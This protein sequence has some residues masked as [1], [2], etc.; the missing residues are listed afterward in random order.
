LNGLSNP[1]VKVGLSGNKKSS[2][3]SFRSKATRSTY[4]V[5]KTLSPQWFD[6]SFVFDV[7]SKASSDP[8]ETRRFSLQCV[9]K[10][11]E[12][13]GKDKFLGQG[14]SIE[15]NSTRAIFHHQFFTHHHTN[16]NLTGSRHNQQLM[17][18]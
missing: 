18:T 13:L 11:S 17:F 6:Q 3:G 1:Y 2:I 5:E 15:H 12:R 9:I 10:S 7:P 4:Y 14:K 8:S 16:R